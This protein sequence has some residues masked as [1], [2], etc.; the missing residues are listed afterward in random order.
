MQAKIGAI[1]VMCLVLTLPAFAQQSARPDPKSIASGNT[2]AAQVVLGVLLY[3]IGPLIGAYGFIRGAGTIIQ[4]HE[5]DK[6]LASM[7]AGAAVGL[8]PHILDKFYGVDLAQKA[9]KMI[10]W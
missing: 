9:A 4:R 6:G 5:V 2:D 3:V 8:T 1:V 10:T 7:G